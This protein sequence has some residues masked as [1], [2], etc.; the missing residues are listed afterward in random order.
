M[1]VGTVARAPALKRWTLPSFEQS[2][3][4]LVF[5]GLPLAIYLIFVISPFVQAFYYSLTDWSGF[6][7]KMTFVGLTNYANLLQDDIFLKALGTAFSWWSSCH[8]W[9]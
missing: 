1:T 3:F 7:K 5:L 8:L 9:S 2:S 4:M 6:S